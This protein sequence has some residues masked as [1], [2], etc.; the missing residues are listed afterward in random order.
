MHGMVCEIGVELRHQL[1][2]DRLAVEPTPCA[3]LSLAAILG[4][5]RLPANSGRSIDTPTEAM[6][7]YMGSRRP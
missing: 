4:F 6:S 5:W 7:P 3:R 1:A 2:A